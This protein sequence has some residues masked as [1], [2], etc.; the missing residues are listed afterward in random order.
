MFDRAVATLKPRTTPCGTVEAFEIQNSKV[1]L[2]SSTDLRVSGYPFFEQI[3]WTNADGFQQIKWTIRNEITPPTRVCDLSFF[4]ET[5]EGHLWYFFGA[6]GPERMRFRLDPLYSPNTGQYNG[7]ISERVDRSN[8]AMASVVTAPLSLRDPIMPPDYGFAV[9]DPSGLVLFHSTAAKNGR[10]QFFTETDYNPS[11]KAAVSS[12]LG[13]YNNATYHGADHRFFIRPLH[14]IQGSNWS[15]IT[16]RNL[17]SRGVLQVERSL[18]FLVLT[19]LYLLVLGLAGLLTIR[20]PEYP[21]RVGC[22]PQRGLQRHILSVRTCLLIV[23][24]LLYLLV[25]NS[26]LSFAVL[27]AG[28]FLYSAL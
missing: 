20:I 15:L 7:I 11:I 16:F 9:V 5:M 19:A 22:V 13:E 3:F 4:T 12:Q 24:V 27:F 25:F 14:G 17:S 10:E 1:Q 6:A 18:L 26:T 28:S 8:V 21:P 23:V 2:L